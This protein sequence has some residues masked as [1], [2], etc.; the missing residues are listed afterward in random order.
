MVLYSIPQSRF[1]KINQKMKLIEELRRQQN[2]ELLK[3][4]NT[5]QDKESRRIHVRASANTEADCSRLDRKF[6]R[7]RVE[8]SKRIMSLT[9]RHEREL[10]Q[11][12]RLLGVSS[13]L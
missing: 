10:E 12:M 11:R 3:V 4:L 13:I 1:K 9:A 6:A 2:A 8:T 5:E 7:E